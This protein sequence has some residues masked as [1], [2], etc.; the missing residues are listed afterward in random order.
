MPPRISTQRRAS[1]S[2]YHGRSSPHDS[3]SNSDIS[4]EPPSARAR[5]EYLSKKPYAQMLET[6]KSEMMKQDYVQKNERL[7][8]RY[9]Y[10][11]SDKKAFGERFAIINQVK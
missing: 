9:S 5:R 8:N 10:F 3:E 1:N 11:F 6:M 4:S 2:T 7:E